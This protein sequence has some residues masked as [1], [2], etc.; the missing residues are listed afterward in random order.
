MRNMTQAMSLILMHDK[1]AMVMNS[2][3]KFFDCLFINKKKEN[4]RIYTDNWRGRT[5][6]RNYLTRSVC[7]M[8]RARICVLVNCEFASEC[9]LCAL[10]STY[11]QPYIWCM[12][13][14][15]IE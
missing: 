6:N 9:E 3:D 2:I 8:C 11:N 7:F 1:H 14:Y 13:A 12:K 10:F 4:K 15:E 5:E